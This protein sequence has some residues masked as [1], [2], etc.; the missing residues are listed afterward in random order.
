MNDKQL[1]Y[2]LAI[3]EYGG[4]SQAAKKLFISQPSLSQY[5]HNLEK[6]LGTI[7]FD[8]NS[9]PIELTNAGRIYVDCAEK[10]LDSYKQME[11]K[12]SDIRDLPHGHVTIG[13]SPDFGESYPQN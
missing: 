6:Q 5:I 11:Q 10:I 3:R 8:R 1:Q 2:V 12:L 9:S 4:I 7:L 13:A